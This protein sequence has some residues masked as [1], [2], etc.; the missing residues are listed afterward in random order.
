MLSI[1]VLVVE[2]VEV[3]VESSRGLRSRSRSRLSR[4]LVVEVVKRV[5]VKVEVVE[6]VEVEDDQGQGWQ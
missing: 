4:S 1:E 3:K 2:R 5:E 6:R